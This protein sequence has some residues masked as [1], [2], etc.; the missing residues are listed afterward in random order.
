MTVTPP[1]D[2]DRARGERAAER[3]R[4]RGGSAME[5]ALAAIEATFSPAFEHS[6]GK[7]RVAALIRQGAAHAQ[8]RSRYQR[9]AE[10]YPLANLDTA[11]AIVERLHRAELEARATAVRLWG[12]CSRPRLTLMLLW[13][14]RLILRMVRRYAPARHAGLVAAVLDADEDAGHMSEAAE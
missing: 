11:I 7:R 13:D 9:L 5:A 1:P 4:A 10:R 6:L 3:V 8:M 2:R 12:R 14:L